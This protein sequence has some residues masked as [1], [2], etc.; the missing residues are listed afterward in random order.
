[1]LN[2]N[3][4]LQRVKYSGATFSGTKSVICA[5]EI[6]VVGHRC[7]Y[8][9]RLPEADRIGVLERWGPCNSLTEVQSFLGTLGVC[10]VFIKGYSEM[11]E[12]LNKLT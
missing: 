3:R 9:G 4:I 5:W 2:M 12:P 8:K 7:T 11:A 10:R 1:M 6:V